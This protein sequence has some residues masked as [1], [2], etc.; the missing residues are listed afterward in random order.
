MKGI[1]RKILLWFGGLLVFSLFAFLATTWYFN[2]RPS[3]F[4]NLRKLQLDDAVMALKLGGKP[5]LADYMARLNGQ[6]TATHYL[7]DGQARDVLTSEDRRELW[8]RA[9]TPSSPQTRP[10]LPWFGPPGRGPD[11]P[12]RETLPDGSYSLLLVLP[13]PDFRSSIWG[14]LPNYLWIVLVIVLLCYALAVTL[15]RP[16]RDLRETMVKFGSGDLDVR[17]HLKRKDEIG[18]LAKAFNDMAGRM[19][20]LLTAE[21]RLLQDISHEL[22]SPLNRLGFAIELA[23]SSP[24]R[25]GALDRIKHESNRLTSLVGELIQM[26]RA[27]G[28]PDERI[29]EPLELAEQVEH[30]VRDAEIEAEVR[31]VKL[32][33][34]WSGNFRVMGDPVLL[35]RALD[36]VLRNAI[37]HTATGTAVEIGIDGQ[38][39]EAVV[40]VRDQGPGVPEEMLASIFKPFFRVES[41]RGRDSGGIGLGLAIA[42]RAVVLHHGEIS[43]HNA[44]PGLVV[45]VRLPLAG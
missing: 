9:V 2:F 17:S 27:E 4:G 24:D 6:F 21:R 10:R 37:R 38:P 16:L 5:A 41:D 40:S 32:L 42:Q 39:G 8:Q 1:F 23:R 44:K 22:R 28:D 43:A 33:R 25:N 3:I 35:A 30:V 18:D 13:E 45:E 31:Q 36:N 34:R 15:A 7:V 20:T 26:T 19:K 12:M 29:N 14:N 11:H